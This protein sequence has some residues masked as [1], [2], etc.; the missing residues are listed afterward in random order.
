MEDNCVLARGG[1]EQ[2]DTNVW[3]VVSELDSA[4]RRGHPASE[5]EAQMTPMVARAMETVNTVLRGKPEGR[6]QT[7]APGR[8][9]VVGDGTNGRFNDVKQGDPSGS[10]WCSCAVTSAMPGTRVRRANRMEVRGP[11]V[12]EK[13]LITMERRVA[14]K[15]DV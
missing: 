11:I 3:S 8:R 6:K 12:A 7:L 10:G 15:M 5:G 9:Q 2:S 13:S 4:G 14:R 1:G